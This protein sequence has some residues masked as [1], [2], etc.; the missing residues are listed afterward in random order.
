MNLPD[1]TEPVYGGVMPELPY[2]DDPAANELLATDPFALLVGLVLYQQVP[3]E[4][5]FMGPLVLEER[6]GGKLDANSIA[7]MSPES[8][9]IV[10]K[11]RPALHRFPGNMAKRTH[12][13][14][15][16]VTEHLEGDPER[17]W[18]GVDDADVLMGRLI[19]LP[20]FGEYKARVYFGVLANRF[21]VRPRGWEAHMPDWP[22]IADVAQ[23]GDI[24]EMK[25][26]KKAWKAE[27][28]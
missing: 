27:E 11:E 24:A 2:T 20:G 3:V 23:P 14:A 13:V 12:A 10:F 26:R 5:A 4:K 15:V 18:R 22:S 17:L 19:D 1:R 16:Y 9:E 7:A 8:L 28:R 21:D 25:L 6:L